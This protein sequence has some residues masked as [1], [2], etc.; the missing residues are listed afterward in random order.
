MKTTAYKNIRACIQLVA[1]VMG[2]ANL[3]IMLMSLYRHDLMSIETKVTREFFL[4]YYGAGLYL[5]GWNILLAIFNNCTSTSGSKFLMRTSTKGIIGT[6]IV[7]VGLTLYFRIFYIEFFGASLGAIS[8][9]SFEFSR[10]LTG[11]TNIKQQ[12]QAILYVKMGMEW[13]IHTYS[14][15]QIITVVCNLL[16]YGMLR[17]ATSIDL[18]KAPEEPP[19]IVGLSRQGMNTEAL[20]SIKVVD[21]VV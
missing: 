19:R 15:V 16:M 17:Y 6:T 7:I 2:L 14:M 20:Q 1:I 10:F 13:L 12:D 11:K 4:C 21:T 8:G 18:W 5:A 9:Q 3:V